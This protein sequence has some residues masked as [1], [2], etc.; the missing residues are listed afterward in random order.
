M[1]YTCN[2]DEL[3]HFGIPGQKWGIRRYQNFDGTYT[4]AGLQRY[5]NSKKNYESKKASYNS[6]K[7][8]SSVSRY[9]K[10]MAKAKVKEAKQKMNK[11]YKHLSQDK[12]ADKGKV[13]YKSGERII[14]N[15]NV[16]GFMSTVG[17]IGYSAAVYGYKTGMISKKAATN[18]ALGTTAL[19]GAA[20]VKRTID[21]LGPNRELRAFYAH[22]SN[23]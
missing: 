5:F 17:T 19:E 10:R 7:S 22:T 8:D 4:Q 1:N 20:F 2:K 13:R 14:G 18:I 16:A 6:L 3:Y 9:E 12:L 21:E 23:Y 11:D 15:S